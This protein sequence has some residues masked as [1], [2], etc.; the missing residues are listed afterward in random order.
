MEMLTGIP[1][2]NILLGRPRRSCEDIFKVILKEYAVRV[3]TEIS[4]LRISFIGRLL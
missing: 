4:R 3:R 1:K 2:G